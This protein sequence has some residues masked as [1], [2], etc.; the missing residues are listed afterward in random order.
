MTVRVSPH[1]KKLVIASA[2][3]FAAEAMTSFMFA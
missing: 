2:V 3:V 1:K